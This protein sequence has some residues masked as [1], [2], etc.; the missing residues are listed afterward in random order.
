MIKK[1]GSLEVEIED[2]LDNI[3][4]LDVERV[5]RYLN[6][7]DNYL[8]LGYKIRF[9]DIPNIKSA[10]YGEIRNAIVF[11]VNTNK[12]EYTKFRD[13]YYDTISKVISAGIEKTAQ[14]LYG[15]EMPKRVRIV[16]T[17]YGTI[18]SPMNIERGTPFVIRIDK[19]VDNTRTR[20]HSEVL[21]HEI[22]AHGFTSAHRNGTE[23]DDNLGIKTIKPYPKH[24]ERLMDLFGRTLLVRTGLM[25]RDEVAMQHKMYE[26]IINEVDEVYYGDSLNQDEFEIKDEGNL[27]KI[28]SNVISNIRR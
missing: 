13:I 15:I 25:K 1:I 24:K 5:G 7:F 12:D 20:N 22:W 10:S 28:V 8:S 17:L 21:I 19:F 23:L 4:N 9:P 11:E 16:P 2:S 27:K 26:D 6:S 18:S 3:I 14:G